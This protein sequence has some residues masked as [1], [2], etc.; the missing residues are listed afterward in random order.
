[1]S[2]LQHKGA[3]FYHSIH[4]KKVTHFRAW[5]KGKTWLYLGMTLAL[6]GGAISPVTLPFMGDDGMLTVRAAT[7][8]SA[9]LVPGQAYDT[10]NHTSSNGQVNQTSNYTTGSTDGH[11]VTNGNWFDLVNDTASTVGYATFNGAV[12]TSQAF[13]MSAQI[14]IDD[15]T[16]GN[17]HNTGDALGFVLTPASSSQLATNVKTATGA[18]LGINGLANSVFIG[19]DLY[20]N[21]SSSGDVDGTTSNGW[22][23]G[24]GSVIAIRSTNSAGALQGADYSSL[25]SS[26]TGTGSQNTTN[27][28]AYMDA[29]DD[30]YTLG[31][32]TGTPSQVTEAISISW[33]PD[34][35]NTAPAGLTSGTLSFTLTPQNSGNAT[36]T[37]TTHLNLQDAITFGF[38]GGTGGNYGNLSVS[39][40]SSTGTLVKGT[41]TVN[42]N[43]INATTNQ[44]IP[45]MPL[46]TIKANIYDTIGVVATS[47]NAADTYDYTAPTVR[48]YTIST[49]S[50]PVQV[51][52]YTSGSTN[53]NA[54][55]VYYSP[56]TNDS[57][58]F[59]F[60]GS[61]TAVTAQTYTSV[62]TD[63][64]MPSSLSSDLTAKVP[65]GY[66]IS[67]IKSTNAAYDGST[68]AGVTG[69]TTA[70]TLSAFLAAHP[71]EYNIDS[72]GTAYNYQVTLTPL[73]QTATFNY[74]WATNTPGTNGN[75]GSLIPFGNPATTSLP[76]S[77]TETGG[78]D[79]SIANPN[80]NLP[81]WTTAPTATANPF[82][83]SVL[84]NSLGWQLTNPVTQTALGSYSGSPYE[85]ATSTTDKAG[86][87][88]TAIKNGSSTGQTF[89][90]SGNAT[91]VSMSADPLTYYLTNSSTNTY[92][93]GGNTFSTQVLP[94]S[95]NLIWTTLAVD[96]SGNPLTDDPNFGESGSPSR[97]Y[98]ANQGDVISN[99]LA[100]SPLADETSSATI[101][102][103]ATVQGLTNVNGSGKTYYLTGGYSYTDDTVS[104]KTATKAYNTL[105]HY[106]TWSDLLAAHPNVT[107]SDPVIAMEVALDQTQ[108]TSKA[109]DQILPG[110]T[111]DPISDLTAGLDRDGTNA[112]NAFSTV[113]GPVQVKITDSSG[114]VID[115][116]NVSSKTGTYTVTY[117][118]LNGA[119][120]TAYQKWLLTHADGSVSD[121]LATLSADENADQTVS[122][123]TLLTVTDDTAL[124]SNSQHT[125]SKI[126][127][128]QPESDLISAFDA[129]G[130]DNDANKNTVNGNVVLVSI[131]DKNNQTVW[132]GL[133][134]DT[135][136]ANTLS[137]GTYTERYTALTGTGQLA[138]QNWLTTHADSS[139]SEYL[140]T[141][142]SDERAANTV[143]TIT[144]LEVI[145]FELPHAG[146][147]GLSTLL[148]L[149][150]L[151]GFLSLSGLAWRSRKEDQ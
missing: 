109:T 30:T 145:Y 27:G 6:F 7:T 60:T 78:T 19:R 44:A 61:A 28:T 45:S 47:P 73:T 68:D 12:D 48:G 52:N 102:L 74:N 37:I 22:V 95:T 75:A 26:A 138:Y 70:A 106:A 25:G 141:L 40:N 42:V 77:S 66:Y 99:Q 4:E 105:T 38:L 117:T 63:S 107:S 14:K 11:T 29:P 110:A 54:I 65:A 94:N 34:A 89:D 13:S 71:N 123:T 67:A 76:G 8:S 111:Y 10:G 82:A 16:L 121:Y 147:I 132:Q 130:Q 97:G 131:T 142:T 84:S 144:Q 129:D 33:T 103:N 59:N 92:Q 148:A 88:T 101:A 21:I 87:T 151:S 136:P 115:A 23:A 108:L 100:G 3:L 20:S 1:M 17:W 36:K 64:A 125:I 114:N 50:S 127:D 149:A 112:D 118:A 83:A 119:G 72:T 116:A 79:S 90:S 96:S 133:S 69:S 18:N 81:I 41:S 15:G 91:N 120:Y 31:I 55:N 126:L 80:P 113:N 93:A 2:L 35:T 122:S 104:S 128:Y 137:A 51:Q 39:L 46:S 124:S 62:T 9:T 24:G 53:P 49:I 98:F 135:L 146:G 43:Y 57:S 150:T 134:T 140:T 32:K 85:V 86:T 143:S 56:N 139:V 58:T 5:K